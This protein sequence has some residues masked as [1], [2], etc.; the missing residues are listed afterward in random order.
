[1]LRFGAIVNCTFVQPL[2][3]FKL[4]VWTKPYCALLFSTC[5]CYLMRTIVIVHGSR[6]F[7]CCTDSAL[8]VAKLVPNCL[9]VIHLL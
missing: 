8:L 4:L 6:L 5:A 3:L 9:S 7:G 2:G 1:M